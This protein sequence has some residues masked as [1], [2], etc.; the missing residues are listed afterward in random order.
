MEWLYIYTEYIILFMHY[1]ACGTMYWAKFGF[2]RYIACPTSSWRTHNLAWTCTPATHSAQWTS[3][4]FTHFK[5]VT[6]V[7]KYFTIETI[8]SAQV[9]I[10]N[11]MTIYTYCYLLRYVT[12]INSGCQGFCKHEKFPYQ[13]DKKDVGSGGLCLYQTRVL[14]NKLV[15]RLMQEK[16]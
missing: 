9:T 14:N 15:I 7:H 16:F 5:I 6:I 13:H 12:R 3:V 4:R 11:T 1:Q 10:I 2:W 8:L